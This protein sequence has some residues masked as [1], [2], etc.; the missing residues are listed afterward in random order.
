M[1]KNKN[2]IPFENN[3]VNIFKVEG[4][5]ENQQLKNHN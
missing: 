4:K 2:I 3:E 5:E 1:K